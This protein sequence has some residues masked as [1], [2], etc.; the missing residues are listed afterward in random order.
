[1]DISQVHIEQRSSGSKFLRVFRHVF[2]VTLNFKPLYFLNY[3]YNN[4]NINIE[5]SE[6][7]YSLF[8]SIIYAVH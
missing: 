6:K 1:M 4:T 5:N 7:K 2:S 8:H 3:C